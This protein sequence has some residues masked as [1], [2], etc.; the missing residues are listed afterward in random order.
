MGETRTVSRPRSPLALLLPP[1][2]GKAPLGDG[3]GWEPT[4]GVFGDELGV[5][6]EQIAA[7]LAAAGGGSEKLLGVGGQHLVRA[8][9]ANSLLVGAPTL[10]ASQRYTGVVWDHL[11]LPSLPRAARARASASIAVVSGL[12][13]VVALDD[14]TPDYR[15]KMGASLPPF[16]KLST[17]WRPELSDALNDWLADRV[18]VDLL[19][20]EHRAAWTSSPERYAGLVTVTFVERDGSKKGAVVGHDAKAAKGLLAR[21]LLL[22]AGSTPASVRAALTS[23]QHPR[24][25]LSLSLT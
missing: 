8:Q 4:D 22:E 6:R 19:P 12:L 13:G 18:V 20:N 14:P 3:P 23:W 15:L 25:A 7:A 11:D 24:F 10:P 21:H 5:W 16:G 1:S 9:A 17:W 2:E